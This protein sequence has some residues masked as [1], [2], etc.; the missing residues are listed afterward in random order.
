MVIKKISVFILVWS[1][2]FSCISL[3]L[4]SIDADFIVYTFNLKQASK[5]TFLDY[6]LKIDHEYGYNVL[7]Y[8]LYNLGIK[9]E[10]PY[11]LVSNIVLYFI[12][13]ST[14]SNM[15]NKLSQRR[16]RAIILMVFFNPLFF[17]LSTNVIRQLLAFSIFFNIV[18][19]NRFL[20]S[21]KKSKFLLLSIP[22]SIHLSS[23]L[24]I[25]GYLIGALKKFDN[26]IFLF[27]MLI[28]PIFLSGFIYRFYELDLFHDTIY[29]PP[30][31]YLLFTSIVMLGYIYYK[32]INKQ[33]FYSY[34]F[35]LALI[36][37]LYNLS[38]FSSRMI[39]IIHFIF[40][41][42]IFLS[43][44]KINVK[45][46]WLFVLLSMFFFIFYTYNYITAF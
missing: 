4:L 44:K 29:D 42:F 30:N 16:K 19:N 45:I 14:I 12:V 32:N 31:V 38:Q 34:Y 36:I 8:V 40:P 17:I 26:R 2:I 9:S 18:T 11:I 35:P 1:L 21:N 28:G 24:L 25:I 10:I 3:T 20:K 46:L 43:M 13:G 6:V 41:F 23:V 37:G 15:S 5:M 39:L 22:I 33:L 7:L 27:L